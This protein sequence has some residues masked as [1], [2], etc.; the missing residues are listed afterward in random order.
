LWKIKVIGVDINGTEDYVVSV[1]GNTGIEL[2][3]AFD[4]DNYI[5]ND[6]V[7]MTADLTESGTPIL[8]AEVYAII[9]TPS[10]SEKESSSEMYDYK[11]KGLCLKNGFKKVIKIIQREK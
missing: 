9:E 4:N 6:T 2:D 1:S 8:N 11:K 3:V 10:T 7:N 5:G